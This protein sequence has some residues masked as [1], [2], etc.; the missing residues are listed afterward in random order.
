MLVVRDRGKRVEVRMRLLRR[1]RRPQ[2]LLMLGGVGRE[3]KR[4]EGVKM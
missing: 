2:V 4:E 1:N 3:V